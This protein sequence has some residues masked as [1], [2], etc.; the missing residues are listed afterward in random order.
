MIATDTEKIYP[1]PELV[2]EKTMGANPDRPGDAI[3][4]YVT[5]RNIGSA[6]A[7][8]YVFR[9]KPLPQAFFVFPQQWAMDFAGVPQVYSEYGAQVFERE[10]NYLNLNPG[11]SLSIHGVLPLNNWNGIA[12]GDSFCN[13]AWIQ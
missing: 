10:G 3:D 5:I 13:D 11:Q 6:A 4:F 12:L 8:D 7:T 1:I 9:D 2:V